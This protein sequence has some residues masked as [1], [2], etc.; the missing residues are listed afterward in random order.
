MHLWVFYVCHGLWSRLKCIWLQNYFHWNTS[1]IT[2]LEQTVQKSTREFIININQAYIHVHI[3]SVK[4]YMDAYSWLGFVLTKKSSINAG[5]DFPGKL[6]NMLLCIMFCR[7]MWRGIIWTA[8]RIL[9]AAIVVVTVNVSVQVWHHTLTAAASRVF[10]L[11][12][13]HPPYAVSD[14]LPAKL[15]IIS[16]T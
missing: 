10:L 3:V 2:V 6:V 8:W 1:G 4:K 15:T 9:A 16:T 13:G 7:W 12:G 11:I 5:T 14:H